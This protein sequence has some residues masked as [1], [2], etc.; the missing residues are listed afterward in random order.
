MNVIYNL[1][2]N[3]IAQLHALYQQEWWTKGRTL[4]EARNCVA[5]SQICVGLL[6]QRTSWSAF[7]GF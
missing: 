3:H 7:P 2:E 5:V 1:T 4:M 6:V